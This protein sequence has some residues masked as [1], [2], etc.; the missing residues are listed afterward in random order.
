MI[1][2]TGPAVLISLLLVF[3]LFGCP[4]SS[5]PPPIEARPSE[6]ELCV[7]LCREKNWDA[8]MP[9]CWVAAGQDRTPEMYDRLAACLLFS[10]RPDPEE[11]VR[12]IREGLEH[13]PGSAHLRTVLISVLAYLGRFEEAERE[14]LSMVRDFPDQP[15]PYYLLGHVELA[16]AEYRRAVMALEKAAAIAPDCDA[17]FSRY[18]CGDMYYKLCRAYFSTGRREEA[19]R[20]CSR[21][22]ELYPQSREFA[23]GLAEVRAAG[24]SSGFSPP[25]G[26]LR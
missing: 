18:E 20:S 14:A 2:R 26:S 3:I 9:Y 22:V 23:N 19:G 21:A 8:A 4:E 13:N 15:K 6:R 5:S 10:E 1:K 16:M 17:S 11:A 12:A 25:A 24:R 7:T